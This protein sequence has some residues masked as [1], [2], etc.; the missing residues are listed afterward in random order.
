MLYTF[1]CQLTGNYVKIVTGRNDKDQQLTFSDVKVFGNDKEKE[2]KEKEE[3]E[4][5][6]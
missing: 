6:A 1:E 3:K 2:R 4:K 5:Q